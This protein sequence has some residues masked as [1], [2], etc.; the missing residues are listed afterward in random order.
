[1]PLLIIIHSTSSII[2]LEQDAPE[3]QVEPFVFAS[4]QMY[5]GVPARASRGGSG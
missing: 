2:D 5:M 1:M 3:E 4:S